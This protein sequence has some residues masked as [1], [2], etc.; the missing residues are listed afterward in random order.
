M[1]SQGSEVVVHVFDVKK[2]NKNKNKNRNGDVFRQDSDFSPDNKSFYLLSLSKSLMI[3]FCACVSYI[4]NS[5]A[6]FVQL[7]L[8]LED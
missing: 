8:C 2:K 6:H 7:D 4:D 3:R 5:T 1:N